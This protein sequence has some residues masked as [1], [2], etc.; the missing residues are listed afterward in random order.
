MI[1]ESLSTKLGTTAG[2]SA[3]RWPSCLA[4]RLTKF[5][6]QGR[7]P[8]VELRN[9]I[10]AFRGVLP[11]VPWANGL[12]ECGGGLAP[13]REARAY[14]KLKLARALRK[15]GPDAVT[16]WPELDLWAGARCL[17][18]GD[19]SEAVSGTDMTTGCCA[20]PGCAKCSA[21]VSLTKTSHFTIC[22]SCDRQRTRRQRIARAASRR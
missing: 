4:G 8:F 22:Q 6:L 18:K 20:S 2:S 7:G 11:V 5:A 14:L 21:L 19:S 12:A 3:L 13:G 10:A 1:R 16:T 9:Q 15:I 17:R